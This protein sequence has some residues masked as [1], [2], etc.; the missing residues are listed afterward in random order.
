MILQ[1]PF[2]EEEEPL[3][4]SFTRNVRRGGDPGKLRLELGL[5]R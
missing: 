1:T 3:V 4:V 2:S 5:L